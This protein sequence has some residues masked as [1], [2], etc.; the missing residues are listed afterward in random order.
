MEYN[1][2]LLRLAILAV[3]LAFSTSLFA[4]PAKPGQT[5][6]LTLTDGT[7]VVATLVG[8]EHGHYWAGADGK[9]YRLVS[10]TDLYEVVDA[11]LVK[12][13]AAVRRAQANKRRANRLPRRIGTVGSITGQKKGLIILVNFSDVS[14]KTANNKALYE[15][16]ANEENFSSGDFKGSMYDYFKAQSGG[17]FELTF[18]VVGPVTVSKARSYYGAHSGN[19]NDRYP[20]TMVIEALKLVDSQVNYR[21]YDWDGDGEVEQ[22]YVVY[23]GQGEADGGSAE[24]I[25]PH[26]WTLS[27]ANYYGDGAGRQTL[28]GVKIDTY[29]CGGE[30]NGSNQIAGIGTMCHEFSHCLGYPDFY[31]TDYSGGQGMFEWDLMDSG[32]YNGDGY[33]PAGYTS[34]ERWVAGW[35]MPVTLDETQSIANMA[36]LQDGGDSYVIYNKGNN[37]EYFLLE[38]RQKKGWDAGLPGKGLLILHVDY[39]A[40]AWSNNEPNDD[41]SHQRM[42][43]IAADNNYQYTTHEGT[44][45][46]TSE[47]AANDPFPYGAVNAFSKTT[48]PAAKFYNKNADNT[49]YLDSSIENITQNSDGTISFRFNDG[50][51][52]GEQGGETTDPTSDPDAKTF[53]LV[54]STDDLVSGKRYII[55]CA[56]KSTAAGALSSQILGSESV[57]VSADVATISDG[58]SVFVLEG[59]Q[60]SGWTFKNESTNQYLYATAA[61]KLAYGSEASTWTL[62]NGTAG[63]IMTFGDYGTM[64]YNASSPRFTTYTSN[65]SATMIQANLY[66]EE[67]TGTTTT[68]ELIADPDALSFETEVGTPQVKT[69]DV[70][71]ADL[72]GDVS[73]TLEGDTQA[74]S[75]ST[76]SITKAD[77]EEGTSVSV[78]FNPSAAGDYSA[79]VT[80]ST[81]GAEDVT[82]SLTGT[83]TAVAVDPE[84]TQ[85]TLLYEGLSKYTADND[86]TAE[87]ATDNTNLDYSGWEAFS[88][89]YA[90]GTSNAHSNGGCLKLGSSK[91]TG[92]VQSGNISL[93]GAGTLTFYLKKYG[94]DTGKL[95]V[96]VTGATADVTQFT[97]SADWTLC[98]VNLTDATGNV[99]FTLATS[100]KRAYVDEITLVGGSS[101]PT[102]QDVT[103]SF[104]PSSVELTYGDDFSQPTL[105][106]MPANLPVTYES[107]NPD[108]A[109]VNATSGAV[110]IEGVG[111]TTITASFAGDNDYNAGSAS[112]TITVNEDPLLAYYQP[113][114]GKAERNLKTAMSGIIYNRTELKYD[115]LWT[116]YRTT[117]VRSDGKIWDM[118]SNITNYDPV[119]GSHSNT[120]EG[121]GF[122]REHSFPKSWF[123][124]EI[125][126]M[127]T[128][129]HHLYPV[130]GYLNTMRS[131]NPFGETNGG[132]FKSANNFSK[133][134][135]C[136]YPGYT[137]K[138]FEPADEY[139]G[140]FARTYFYMVTCYE[141]KLHDWYTNYGPTTEVDDVLDGNTYPGFS[142][143]QL[144]MLMEWAKNDP[145]SEKETARN[146]A[147]YA[148]QGN[149]NPFI[150]YPGLQEYIW[151]FMTDVSFSYDNY[152]VPVYKTDVT[153]AFNPTAAEATVGADFTEPTLTMTPTGLAVTYESSATA[154]ATV[155]ATTGEVTPLTAGTTT[156]TAA[157]AGNDLYNAATASYTLTVAAPVTPPDPTTGT[158][159]YV[160]VT[161]AMTL[162][163]GD[164]IIIVNAD[165]DKALSTTQN[166]NNR[167]AKSVSTN[168]DGTI[169]PSEAV[170]VI[171]LE[172]ADGKFLFNVG[173]GYLYAA[174]SGSNYLKTENTAD[175]N[176]QATISISSDVA[177][178][179]FQGTN[180]RNTMRYNPNNGNPIFSCYASTSTVGSLVKIYR[181]QQAVDVTL[182]N[183]SDNTAVIAAH[184]GRLANVTLA[185]RKL[186]KDA[187]W[188]TLC[189]PFDVTDL[190]TTPLAGAT[191]ME[192]NTNSTFNPSTGT[193]TVNFTTAETMEAGKAYVLKWD[194]GT[195]I[196]DPVFQ[197][198]TL[199]NAAPQATTSTDGKVQFVGI[200]S[201]A[202]LVANTTA[203]L[204]M[205]SD[206]LLYFPTK[207]GFSVK[208]CRAYFLVDLSD[209]SEVREQ[210]VSFED[211]N[212]GISSVDGQQDGDGAL[213]RGYDLSGRRVNVQ[214]GRRM[215]KGI[216]IIDGKKILR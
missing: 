162:A 38:N 108:V 14:F 186:Y 89:V 180:T 192:M 110:S 97:P 119:N 144:N 4:V 121:S 146:E 156:I 170:Q 11:D 96:S 200:Y 84:P 123:G 143:W 113:A 106:T 158:G 25:W 99:S 137:G 111:T 27:S 161:D 104:S 53:R 52:S 136:T 22:V 85:T 93:T 95:N 133:L 125:M 5:K 199:E 87:L 94:S 73:V 39:S 171:T 188:N 129:L 152:Q 184:D 77:A 9:A 75:L 196:A 90:G 43:W 142:E 140:D 45:Y 64:L 109:T 155:D 178:V 195:D 210:L 183:A 82:I 1:F 149:R 28:D 44:K 134:G 139:K 206:N 91:A 79:T 115:D 26:E 76:N 63:V 153:M 128:D 216:Y 54:S 6:S 132:N 58:V 33:Q 56:S 168:A 59:N 207:E 16:I 69:F 167:V 204:Y 100:S 10:G 103:M 174:S 12:R 131:N 57:T 116:A 189:L 48:T 30:L 135:S 34:Y 190:S 169:T 122:N 172:V 208:A 61:K 71:G 117:D 150:D 65:P 205:G 47:G 17:Q 201:P 145:V 176:A 213:Q 191:V 214:A 66:M 86:G 23:A 159:R 194:E 215:P 68:P 8:D 175:A 51:G 3:W 49:Y 112:Y 120:A 157:F 7:T 160:L 166:A 80:L 177:T 13:H 102:T 138:V 81:A 29:A 32:S 181:E 74:F 67:S 46:Y 187:S 197:G 185:G 114:D 2:K 72:T 15:R 24:T 105:T 193:L 163:A 41:P 154:V 40:T 37:N 70:L 92:S 98:T 20:A 124:G 182:E 198:V 141:E 165:A 83:A 19:D 60:T 42:T 88:K 21:D 50:T 126:P 62:S 173:G 211:V 130:D 147:V 209:G 55:A 118:Y 212:T 127:Y 179:T 35:K 18:D 107:N 203:N 36:A 78:D 148:Q 164:K 101:T 31:D 151:G 202:T